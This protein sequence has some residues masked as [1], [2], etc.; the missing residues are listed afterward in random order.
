MDTR[1]EKANDLLSQFKGDAYVHGISC[2]DQL[3]QQASSMGTTA[4]VVTDGI[5]TSWA[6][7]VHDATKAALSSAGVTVQGDLIAGANPN[8]PREDV[9]RIAG[10]IASR[11]PDVVVSVGGGS[12]IDATKAATAMVALGESHTDIEE[13]FGVGKVTEMLQAEG[14]QMKPTV[15]VQL[16]ASSG[17]HLT[18]YSNVTDVSS[19]QKKLIVDE[20]VVPR[21]ALFDYAST[22]TMPAGFTADGGLDGIAHCL[23]VFYGLKGDALEKVR[24]VSMLGIEIIVN[25]IKQACQSPE[26]LVSREALGLGTDLGG[27]AIMIGGTNGAHLTSFSLVDVL[28][29]GRACALMNPYYTVFFAPAIQ[30]QLRGVGGILKDA[31]YL[32]SSIDTLSGRDLG[33][34]V[35]EGMLEL[36]RAINFPTTLGEVDGFTQAHID[37]ALSAAKNPQLE[38]KL[39]NMPVPLSSELVDDYMGPILEAAKTGDFSVIRNMQEKV[40]A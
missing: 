37:R 14:A 2:F 24:P 26:D 11:N 29:H 15:A 23:E 13:Y 33:V 16:A 12:V 35:A 19:H 31:G 28:S 39:K 18:K 30:D 32:K 6:T 25:Y 7:P 21:K 4:A 3:G 9:S 40:Q 34:A 8:A 17:A 20:A 1:F 22:V 38:M 5:A 36:S 10:E 27:Y